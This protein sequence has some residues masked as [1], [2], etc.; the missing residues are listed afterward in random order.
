MSTAKP[1]IPV[2]P[3]KDQTEEAVICRSVA[4]MPMEEE[5]ESDQNQKIKSTKIAVEVTFKIA[6]ESAFKEYYD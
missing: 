2:R 3:R 1:A 6:Y 4:A 5:Q